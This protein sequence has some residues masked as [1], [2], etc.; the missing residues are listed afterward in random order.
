LIDEAYQMIPRDTSGRDFGYEAVETLMST[1]EGSDATTDDR[2]AMIFAGYPDDMERFIN[3]NS[4]LRRRITDTFHFENYSLSDLF[5]IYVKMAHK[6]GF[7]VAI[8][9]QLAATEMALSFD[10]NIC[11]QLNAGIS[12]ELLSASKSNVNHRVMQKVS[13]GV[14][15]VDLR[16]ELMEIAVED[17]VQA[18]KA[19]GAKLRK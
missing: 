17:F 10:S 3:C 11:A 7:C 2:P 14:L 15:I 12:R 13:S 19:V 4:G 18:C 6:A 8:D 1:I 16:K 5:E 9:E